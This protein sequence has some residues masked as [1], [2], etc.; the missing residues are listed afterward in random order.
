MLMVTPENFSVQSVWIVLT[1]TLGVFILCAGLEG[2]MRRHIPLIM[3]GLL[4]V[5]GFLLMYP[6]TLTDYAGFGIAA[7]LILQQ[8]IGFGGKQIEKS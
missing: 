1:A 7:L 6:G 2:F 4:I 8:F 5:G 3:R